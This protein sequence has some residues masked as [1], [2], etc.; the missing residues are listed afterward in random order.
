MPVSQTNQPDGKSKG[1][2]TVILAIGGA[3]WG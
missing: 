1:I 2:P 3:F